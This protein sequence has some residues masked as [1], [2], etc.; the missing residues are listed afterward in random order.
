MPCRRDGQRKVSFGGCEVMYCS[1]CGAAL[2]GCARFCSECGKQ[3][4][5]A[6]GGNVVDTGGGSIKGGVYQ[7]GHD[8]VVNPPTA[9]SMPSVPTYDPVPKW[10]SPFTQAVLTWISVGLGIL[11]L[12]PLWQIFKPLVDLVKDGSLLSVG[13]SQFVWVCVFFGIAV[14]FVVAIS[15]RRITATRIRRP[16]A[17]GWALS[18]TGG[19]LTVEQVRVSPC[20]ICRGKLKYYTKPLEWIDSTDANGHRHREIT[21][22]APALECK[23]NPKHWWPVDPAEDEDGQA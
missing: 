18:G 21:D 6:S 17:F 13:A 3:V 11:S 20:P 19:R 4:G 7:A 12:L 10:R 5:Q 1:N 14:L 15:L 8:V 16:L 2:T 23:R 22:S 9:P